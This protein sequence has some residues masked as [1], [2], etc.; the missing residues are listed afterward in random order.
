[1]MKKDI[2]NGPISLDWIEPTVITEKFQFLTPIFGGGVIPGQIDKITKVRSASIIGQLR[3]WWRAARAGQFESIKEM[4][5]AEACLWG[6][7]DSQ[8]NIHEAAISLSLNIDSITIEKELNFNQLKRPAIQ[9][10]A[11]PL[12]PEEDKKNKQQ[13]DKK[14]PE[15]KITHLK[16]TVTLTLK[17]KTNLF[18]SCDKKEL[19]L[20]E[21]A[22]AALWAWRHFGGFGGRTRRGFGALSVENLESLTNKLLHSKYIIDKKPPKNVPSLAPCTGAEIHFSKEI[23]NAEKTWQRLALNYKKFRQGAKVGRN[24]SSDPKK[25]AGRSLWPEADIIRHDIKERYQGSPKYRERLVPIIKAKAPRAQFGLP[26]IFSFH[27]DNKAIDNV[28]LNL[29]DAERYTS[30]LILRPVGTRDK[31]KAMILVLGNRLNL[32][33]TNG[34][35]QMTQNGTPNYPIGTYL[36]VDEMKKIQPLAQRLTKDNSRKQDPV[37]AFVEFAIERSIVER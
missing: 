15:K 20:E 26:I 31:A 23:S 6:G 22:K 37:L 10:F 16:G 28:T 17:L 12:R 11:F 19:N 32:D 24:P 21:E 13:K 14:E 33:T 25:P 3:F 9:Y 18:S 35:L 5:D 34:G 4:K 7:M 8:N 29:K 36:E 30:P 2:K 1:M 27:S